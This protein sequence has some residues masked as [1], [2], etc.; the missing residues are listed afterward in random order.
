MLFKAK[1]KSTESYTNYDPGTFFTFSLAC[2]GKLNITS[3]TQWC[4]FIGIEFFL[5]C[6]NILWT[7]FKFRTLLWALLYFQYALKNCCKYIYLYFQKIDILAILKFMIPPI[8]IF[9]LKLN[10]DREHHL[11]L[12]F[13]I[14]PRILKYQYLS[15]TYAILTAW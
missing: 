12:L 4:Q 11:Y 3:Q 14:I 1:E 9:L 13:I 8:S 10:D 7:F 5:F 15:T 6:S 2:M